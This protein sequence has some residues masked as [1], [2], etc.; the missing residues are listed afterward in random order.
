M[1]TFLGNGSVWD[2]ENNKNLCTFVDGKFSTDS[3]YI[4]DKLLKRGNKEVTP[5][6][7]TESEAKEQP[8]KTVKKK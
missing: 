2:A 4:A 1:R 8:K 6:K 3:K 7:K 5:K